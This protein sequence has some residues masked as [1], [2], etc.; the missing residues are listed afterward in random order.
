[1]KKNKTYTEDDIKNA[2]YD[3]E[4]NETTLRKAA[5]KFNIPKSTLKDRKSNGNND[6]H[7]NGSTTNLSKQTEQL[8]VHMLKSL[9][10]W[11]YGLTFIEVQDLVFEYLKQTN[12]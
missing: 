8:L 12:Q 5:F 7:G 2:L 6:F 1:M 9:S 10:D 3:M 11:G 4:T